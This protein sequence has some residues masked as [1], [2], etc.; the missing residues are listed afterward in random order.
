[1]NLSEIL[2]RRDKATAEPWRVD[3]ATS[4]ARHEA[5][6]DF[7]YTL[8]DAVAMLEAVRDLMA[9][10]PPVD[11]E[12]RDEWGDYNPAPGDLSVDSTNQ[13]DVHSHG[14][15]VGEQAVHKKLLAITSGGKRCLSR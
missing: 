7:L 3:T 4:F 14:Y 6:K 10:L 1:M 9:E 8:P 15:T 11:W 12:P 13:G 5:N 2:R